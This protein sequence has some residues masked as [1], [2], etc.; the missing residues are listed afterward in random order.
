[1]WLYDLD[2]WTYS[3]VYLVYRVY[4]VL[5]V[6]NDYTGFTYSQTTE[7]PKKN[8]KLFKGSV[9]VKLKV[10]LHLISYMV[11]FKTFAW[12]TM[13]ELF[14]FSYLIIWFFLIAVPHKLLAVS[15]SQRH[16]TNN[17][18]SLYLFK[19]LDQIQGNFYKVLI[20]DIKITLSPRFI[21]FIIQNKLTLF[22]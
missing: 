13:I 4:C 11:P 19:F 3:L 17:W 8:R 5:Y 15:W 14:L 10:A 6:L 16:G 2:S 20:R 1:M 12:A 21:K 22:F 7:C 9:F 18:Q